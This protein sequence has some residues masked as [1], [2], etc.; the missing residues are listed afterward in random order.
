MNTRYQIAMLMVAKGGGVRDITVGDCLELR[1]TEARVHVHAGSGRS[2]FYNWLRQ[3][4]NF[5]T[6]APTTLRDVS[7][8]SGQV[9]AAELVDR[10]QLRCRPVRDLIVDDL[11]ERQP[12]LD[13]NSLED[14]SRTLARHFW[15]DLERHHPGIGSL[16]LASTGRND[17]AP[18]PRSADCPTAPQPRPRVLERTASTR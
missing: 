6:E 9:S 3:L 13:H 14:L 7:R 15:A 11:T 10:H 1:E 16:R 18:G 5:P 8:H 4:G 17:A 12:S 2:L